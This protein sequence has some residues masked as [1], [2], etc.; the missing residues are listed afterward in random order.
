MDLSPATL[1]QFTCHKNFRE[2]LRSFM[3]I[4]SQT[5]EAPVPVNCTKII[6]LLI[7]GCQNKKL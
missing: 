4:R 7:S 5:L 3:K 2:T 1:Q 6:E